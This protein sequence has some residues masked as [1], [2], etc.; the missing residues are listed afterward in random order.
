MRV[1]RAF[2]GRCLA[3]IATLVLALA[4]SGALAQ[5]TPDRLAFVVGNGAY[6]RRADNQPLQS[7]KLNLVTPRADALA[8]V[9][10][11]E[12]MGWQVINEAFLDR[13]ARA[14]RDDLAAAAKQITSGSEVVFVFNGHGFSENSAN[15]LVGVPNSGERYKSPGDL[16]TGSVSL[17]EV[18]KA[19][20]EGGPKRIVLIINACGDEPLLSNSSRRPVRQDFD[21]IN[22][23]LLVLYSSSPR[24]I[25]YDVVSNSER[26]EAEMEGA[27]PVYSL[28]TRNFLEQ[29]REE[30]PLLSIFTDVRIAVEH[31]SGFAAAERVRSG[32]LQRLRQIPHVLIDSIDGRF[33][34]ADSGTSTETDESADW[35]ADPRLCR[36][37]PE[38]LQQAIALRAEGKMG[39]G[40]LGDAVKACI[41]EGA[42]GDLGIAK[43]G[44]D[45]EER[46]VI[47][48]QA[49][50]V[51][52]FHDGDR[53]AIVNVF[54]AGEPRQ[55]V[56]FGSLGVFNS[57]LARTY[58][59]PGSQFAFAWKRSDGTLPGSGF[60]A[61]SF[62]E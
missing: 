53:I 28:F 12:E 14:L 33:Q 32:A 57:L 8:Y 6:E 22:A 56:S 5:P 27:D 61:R 24:G 59:L 60:E 43:V 49:S 4:G 35:R 7:S 15:Y 41:V 20:S 48:G 45:A 36:V 23:E 55:R 13:S 29:I 51:S 9:D 11:L 52:T 19:L 34:L 25:A 37:D 42:L 1:T 38:A 2:S 50:T 31:Q 26:T 21:D 17:E 62:E 3:A 16:Q 18:V 58:F 39:A 30:R 44:Y 46:S 47:V 40:V 54:L 10:V